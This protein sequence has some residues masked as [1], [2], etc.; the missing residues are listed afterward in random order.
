MTWSRE[1][2]NHA[3]V[4][5]WRL[6]P[7]KKE[8]RRRCRHSTRNMRPH[9]RLRTG[10]PWFER[11]WLPSGAAGPFWIRI[12]ASRSAGSPVP[13]RPQVPRRKS[14]TSPTPC[15]G[16]SSSP[17]HRS[18]SSGPTLRS[19]R[20]MDSPIREPPAAATFPPPEASPDC[21]GRASA[22]RRWRT[23]VPVCF[24]PRGRSP[25]SS[26][27]LARCRCSTRP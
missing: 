6:P 21:S 2:V 15:A 20:W 7:R 11:S 12:F 13:L 4:S 16:S 10:S 5:V 19:S 9:R 27:F 25:R 24:G 23:L 22:R 18:R 17:K 14:S 8:S 1:P 26:S 3:G